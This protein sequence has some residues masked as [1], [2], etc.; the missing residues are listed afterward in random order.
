[1]E[2]V[3]NGFGNPA[4]SS[5]RYPYEDERGA[6][7]VERMS[8]IQEA[9]EY[10]NSRSGLASRSTKSTLLW[11][12]HN[13]NTSEVPSTPRSSRL[14]RL[15]SGTWNSWSMLRSDDTASIDQSIVPDYVINFLK[16]ET[17]ESLARKREANRWGQRDVVIN[18][19]NDTLS[20]HLVE[21]GNHFASTT[22]LTHGAGNHSQRSGTRRHLSSWRGGVLYNALLALLVLIATIVCLILVVLQT[23]AF[24]KQLAIFSGDCSKAR[25]MNIGLHAVVNVS[26][27]VLLAGANYIFQIL[28]SPTREEVAE[29]HDRKRWLDIGVPSIRNFFHVSGFRAVTGTMILVVAIGIQVIFNAII[30]FQ[31]DTATECVVSVNSSMLIVAAILNAVLVINM[32]VIL[33][34]SS[35]DPLATLGDAIRSFLC[36]PDPTTTE[37]YMLTKA[38]IQQGLWVSPKTKPVVS[39]TNNYWLQAPSLSRWALTVLSWVAVGAPTAAAFALMTRASSGGLATPFGTATPETTFSF[40]SEPSIVV[41]PQLAL[42]AALP[43][44]L[45]A[46]LYLSTNALLTTFFL[47]HELS[48]FALEQRPRPLRVSSAPRGTQTAS[49]YLSLPRPV[50]WVMLAIFAGSSF[51]LS[52]AVFPLIDSNPSSAPTSAVGFNPQALLVLFALLGILLLIILGLGFRRYNYSHSPIVT[53]QSPGKGKGRNPLAQTI[54]KGGGGGASCSAVLSSLCHHTAPGESQIWLRPVNLGDRVLYPER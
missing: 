26:A 32:I 48:L 43:Q 34:M 25:R 3:G 31:Q 15:R 49:L 24:S 10:S 22:D 27:V 12:F 45:L 13:R 52:Q 16:G 40:P 42:I 54:I 50:S 6:R 53:H 5:Y 51:A 38:D 29:A 19:R 18:P 8:S 21:L 14:G 4:G 41:M 28:M 7:T 35:F 47:S 9:T 2:Q 33:T 46:I 1:M 23:K 11:P 44:V 30:Y 17:P 20:S 39:G 37:H 36:T